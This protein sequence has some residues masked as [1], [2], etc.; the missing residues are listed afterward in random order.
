MRTFW[1]FFP[2]AASLMPR[3]LSLSTLLLA[4]SL[5][6]PEL[7]IESAGIYVVAQM[8]AVETSAAGN[9]HR[10]NGAATPPPVKAAS[11]TVLTTA[12]ETMPPKAKG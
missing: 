10:G 6:M 9:S 4:R 1:R 3:L 12:R 11:P 8:Q 5:Q 7:L 2:T